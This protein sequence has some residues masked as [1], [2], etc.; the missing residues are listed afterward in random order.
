MSVQYPALRRTPEQ[1]AERALASAVAP[2]GVLLV[3]HHADVDVE[4]AK[5]HGFD[6]ADYVQHD[7]VLAVLGAGWHVEVDEVRPRGDIGG[8]GGR[9]KD[10]LILLAWRLPDSP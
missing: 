9:H 6:P 2:G 5:A 8:G 1:E 4:T 10:D 7:D 3:V